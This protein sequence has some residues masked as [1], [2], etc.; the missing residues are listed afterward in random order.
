[1]VTAAARMDPSRPTRLATSDGIDLA[2]EA[3]GDEIPEMGMVLGFARSA[4]SEYGD[5][6][7]AFTGT[8]ATG[9]NALDVMAQFLQFDFFSRNTSDIVFIPLIRSYRLDL[10]FGCVFC[11]RKLW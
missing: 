11:M 9:S 8:M 1:M 4:L 2:L 7:A 5:F 10:C 3:F 6:D